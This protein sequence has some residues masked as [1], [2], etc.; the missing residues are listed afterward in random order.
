MLDWHL[1]GDDG[2]SALVA[3]VDDFQEITTLVAGEGGEA[4]VVKEERSALGSTT[5]RVSF[6]LT[7]IFASFLIFIF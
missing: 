2:R 1:T 6:D 7:G 5:R 3:I 4:P